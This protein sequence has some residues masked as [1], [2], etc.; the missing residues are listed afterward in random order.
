M[1]TASYVSPA[2]R[3][4]HQQAQRAGIAIVNEVGLDPGIDHMSA[5][6]VIDEVHSSCFTATRYLE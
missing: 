5:M 2:M 6:K 1:V 4:L 3:E